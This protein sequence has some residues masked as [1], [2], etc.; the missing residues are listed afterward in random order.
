MNWF[1]N[2]SV[3][4]ATR[5]AK[6]KVISPML[7]THFRMQVILPEN[8][9]SDAFGTFSGEVERPDDALNTLRLKC[10]AAMQAANC[11]LGIGSEGSFGPHPFYGFGYAGEELMMLIDQKNQLEITVSMICPETN[12]SGSQIE[13]VN[14]LEAFAV[15]AQFPSHALI[16]RNAKGGVEMILKG[17]NDRTKLLSAY[18]LIR[19]RYGSVYAETDMRAMYNPTRMK[20]ISR[21]TQKLIEKIKCE[22]PECGTPGFEVRE[23][24][25]GLP[26]RVCNVPTR[27]ALVHLYA[28]SKCNCIREKKY[29]HGK[30]SEDPTFCDSCN[31]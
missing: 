13:D 16:L 11:D 27:S 28:C 5:H 12:F 22:C 8:F 24:I 29:P 2:R 6:E 26:C 4:I 15:R 7:E 17:L 20:A 23:S 21:L 9:D 31:P 30:E 14:Q 10:I 1:E 3:V 25:R 18:E 19:N